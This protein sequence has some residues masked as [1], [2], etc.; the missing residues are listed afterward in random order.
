MYPYATG[1]E[2]PREKNSYRAANV[3]PLKPSHP[4]PITSGLTLRP[5]IEYE[6]VEPRFNLRVGD[7]RVTS[8]PAVTVDTM[9]K[10]NGSITPRRQ[11]PS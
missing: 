1:L 6:Y 10:H 11:Q 3:P 2:S 8:L 9:H 4:E 5:E 7:I